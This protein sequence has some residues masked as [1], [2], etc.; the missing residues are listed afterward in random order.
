MFVRPKRPSHSI[1]MAPLIDVVFLLLVFF[2]LT[3]S[4][5]MPSMPLKLPGASGVTSA[6]ADAIT[7]SVAAD[8]GIEIDGEIVTLEGFVPALRGK[9]EGSPDRG[10]NFRGDR[11]TDYGLF[12]DLFDRARQAGVTQLN[13]VH[14]PSAKP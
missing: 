3:S 6:R 5:T 8:G 10:V 4:F 7:I 11:E 14:E 13:L 2:M 1:D 9:I 12:I